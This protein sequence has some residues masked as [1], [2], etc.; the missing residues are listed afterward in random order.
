MRLNPL[1]SNNKAV[2]NSLYSCWLYHYQTRKII[3]PNFSS[4][5]CDFG[6]HNHGDY[7]AWPNRLP[8]VA[9]DQVW[10]FFNEDE[11]EYDF[12]RVALFHLEGDAARPQESKMIKKAKKE[13]AKWEQILLYS[14][15][16]MNRR[17]TPK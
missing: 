14:E 3:F 9:A 1:Y 7:I 15:I 2:N 12:T 5:F 6:M 17:M 10:V 4:S 13:L 11:I 8:P 16:Y